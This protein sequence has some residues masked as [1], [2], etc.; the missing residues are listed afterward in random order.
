MDET[1][2]QQTPTEQGLDTPT[3]AAEATPTA[4]QLL[5]RMREQAGV[6]LE[7]IASALKVNPQKL[8]A[9]EADDFSALPA[10]FFARG[11]AANVCRHLHQDPTPV[12]E[13]MPDEKPKV[14]GAPDTPST[15]MRARAFVPSGMHATSSRRSLWLMGGIMVLL[16]GAA[17]LFALPALNARYG[18][19]L[20]G[21][22]DAASAPAPVQ[23][24]AS[25]AVPAAALPATLQAAP[26]TS[27]PASA[28]SAAV[29]SASASAQ[30]ANAQALLIAATGDTWVQVRNAR[31]QTLYKGSLVAG[32]QHALEVKT[33]PVRLT[34][35]RAENTQITDR[36][37]PFDLAAVAA[38][39]VARFELKP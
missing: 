23:A 35:G 14:A 33:Y 19:M 24:P 4:G 15:P 28:A 39:G 31:G 2:N 34:V 20:R 6:E 9:L 8:R 27:A 5:K 12:L 38:Q 18:N 3:P 10:V 36:G 22:T 29:S 37:T 13:K 32:Q 7:T 1:M 26:A 16:A 25:S 17:A 11:L 21:R 30:A